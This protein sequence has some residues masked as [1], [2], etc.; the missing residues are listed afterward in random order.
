[1]DDTLDHPHRAAGPSRA[2]R[3]ALLVLAF[4]AA[5]GSLVGALVHFALGTTRLAPGETHVEVLTSMELP[6]AGTPGAGDE[7]GIISAGFDTARIVATGLSDATR[8]VLGAGTIIT[9]LTILVVGGAIAWLL[10]LAASGKPFRRSLR[11]STRAAGTALTFGPL[12]ALGLTGLGQ[13]WAADELRHLADDVL[14]P[15]F[16]V[17]LLAFAIPVV[18]LAVLALSY[19]FDVGERLQRDTEGLV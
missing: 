3:I 9:A 16:S 13:M 17:P 2:D 14:V 19:V 11:V 1:M 6:H 5:A 4:I 18:G 10:A 7:P 8:L 12:L 15:G